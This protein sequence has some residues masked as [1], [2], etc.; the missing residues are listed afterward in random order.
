MHLETTVSISYEKGDCCF[1]HFGYATR[2]LT[3][4]EY[5]LYILLFEKPSNFDYASTVDSDG[6]IYQA[7]V[8]NR[9]LIE[10]RTGLFYFY[11]SD[12]VF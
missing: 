12:F 2:K 11:P 9:I 1:T 3:P 5:S 8:S 10:S 7:F 6:S 4:K